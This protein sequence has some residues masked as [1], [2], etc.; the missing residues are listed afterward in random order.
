MGPGPGEGGS[1]P[2]AARACMVCSGFRWG[3]IQ[4]TLYTL[5]SLP[6]AEDLTKEIWSLWRGTESLA[7]LRER[8]GKRVVML[9]GCSG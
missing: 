1:V 2:S 8:M 9:G 7:W 6:S 4:N 3:H 5:V